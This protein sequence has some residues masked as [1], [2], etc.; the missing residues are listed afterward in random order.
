[1]REVVEQIR[2]CYKAIGLGACRE[3][4]EVFGQLAP[5]DDGGWVV[6]D[7]ADTGREHP[8]RDVVALDLFGSVPPHF[9]VV[10]VEPETWVED[11]GGRWLVVTGHYRTRPRGGWDVVRL[12][13][14]H[15][16]RLGRD[17]VERVV[18]YLDGVE[19]RRRPARPGGRDGS[20]GVVADG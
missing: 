9:E 7:W 11:E 13:F 15:V 4:L 19:L 17:G 1:M 6:R 3:V 5:G 12:P 20:G 8:S 18:S 14:A 2:R 10:G 16:W